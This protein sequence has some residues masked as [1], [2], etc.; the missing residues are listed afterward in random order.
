M[1]RKISTIEKVRA[2]AASL[3]ALALAEAENGSPREG[4]GVYPLSPAGATSI[5]ADASVFPRTL[6]VPTVADVFYREN[7]IRS[8]LAKSAAKSDAALADA[9]RD[10]RSAGGRLGRWEV[11]A[12]SA[13]ETLGRTVS[14]AEVKR[15]YADAGGDL[16]ASYTGRGTRA[17]ATA[18]RTDE[19]AA[20]RER[21]RFEKSRAA[22]RTAAKRKAAKAAAEKAAK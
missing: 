11:V 8:P 6:L 16:A 1:A 17:G 13:S 7:G 21:T 14:V 10:R 20:I 3:Y 19:T 15:L 4:F 2:D 18:T 12:Y 22:K 5:L 9:I